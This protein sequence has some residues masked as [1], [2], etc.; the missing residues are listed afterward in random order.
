MMTFVLTVISGTLIFVVGQIFLK[1]VIEPALELRK[2]LGD[3]SKTLLIH[4]ARLTNANPD[5]DIASTL[6]SDSAEL[7]SRSDVV[8]C[9]AFAEKIFNL[10]SKSEILLA[11]RELNGMSYT[12]RKDNPDNITKKT[13]FAE[14]NTTA[15]KNVGELLKLQTTYENR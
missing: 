15:I 11:S 13:K 9:Y 8:L 14:D 3:V 1:L 12:M 10:P 7:L 2:T 6:I 5:N 4:Q